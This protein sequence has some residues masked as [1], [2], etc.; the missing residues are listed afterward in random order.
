M[1]QFY[2]V[3]FGCRR[4]C[5]ESSLRKLLDQSLEDSGIGLDQISALASIDKKRDEPGLLALAKT[6]SKP[7][8]FFPSVQLSTYDHGISQISD[9]AL[10][11]TG[12]VSVAEAAALA[13]IES[14]HEGR[15]ANLAISKRSN[16]E[17]TFA[18]AVVT[19]QE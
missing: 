19:L 16:G 4:G 10:K 15:H 13:C 12:S 7:L 17:A 5:S 6:L 8:Q 9:L 2:A 14:L 1:K 11:Q 3:G 18:L